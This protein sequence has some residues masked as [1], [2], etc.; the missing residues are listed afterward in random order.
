MDGAEEGLA[1]R[2]HG[3]E[4]VG[5]GVPVVP[6]AA[7]GVVA[8]EDCDAVCF[9]V[10]GDGAGVGDRFGEKEDRSG[11]TG[12]GVPQRR[13]DIVRG[14]RALE[15]GFVAVGDEECAAGPFFDGVEFPDDA[16]QTAVGFFRAAVIG[17]MIARE[18]EHT[19]TC[20]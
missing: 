20:A 12:V 2:G 14:G 6:F 13:G 11:G 17:V 15:D 8:I 5:V 16:G 18:S 1:F 10:C 4:V 9:F 3:G 7:E 19:I